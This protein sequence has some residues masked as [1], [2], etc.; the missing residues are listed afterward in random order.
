MATAPSSGAETDA[1]EPLNWPTGCQW[2]I[3][4]SIY[5]SQL[6]FAVGVRDAARMYASW[7]S[8]H[9]GRAELN[10]RWARNAGKARLGRRADK[11]EEIMPILHNAG[12]LEVLKDYGT[13]KERSQT[14]EL[15]NDLVAC[16]HR[17]AS[18]HPPVQPPI[19]AAPLGPRLQGR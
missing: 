5:P 8:F 12:D 10:C 7:I 16:A 19:T 9:A 17:N 13:Q 15:G 14:E 11:P 6:T 2:V 4:Y 18:M 3:S 1:K